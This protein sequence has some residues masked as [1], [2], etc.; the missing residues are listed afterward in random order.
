M[1]SIC[2]AVTCLTVKRLDAMQRGLLLV[3]LLLPMMLVQLHL[4][5]AELVFST[6]GPCQISQDVA[7]CC[8]GWGGYCLTPNQMR[9]RALWEGFTAPT[10]R[11]VPCPPGGVLG[12]N[13]GMGVQL[14]VGI[15]GTNPS[16]PGRAKFSLRLRC[17]GGLCLAYYS[18]EC[19]E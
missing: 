8:G 17:F 13:L 1:S 9:C 7:D 2:M 18:S 15:H 3:W 14:F 10:G 5:L 4:L 11:F 12:R 16:Q 6:G 19:L